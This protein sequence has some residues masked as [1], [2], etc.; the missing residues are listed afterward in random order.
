[1][2]L[3]MREGFRDVRADIR[4]LRGELG[5]VRADL[6]GGIGG[7]R[8]DVA[9]EI[10]GVRGEIGGLR[11]DTDAS[12]RMVYAQLDLERRWLVG[13]WLTTALGFVAL[14]LELHVR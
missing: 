4:D 2:R 3:E 12:F 14:L 9:G 10:R 8:A 6:S 1:M 13:M 7:V 5:G 11:A